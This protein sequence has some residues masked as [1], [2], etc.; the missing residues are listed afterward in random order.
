MTTWVSEKWNTKDAKERQHTLTGSR[1]EGGGGG[2]G[3]ALAL[4]S[5]LVILGI[6]MM[7][8]EHAVERHGE[9]VLEIDRVCRNGGMQDTMWN[10]FTGRSVM[11]CQVEGK[12][13]LA[14]Y[15][16]GKLV[17]AFFKEKMQTLREVQR[18]LM[19]AGYVK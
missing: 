10:P 4:V 5:V 18:Y 14:V 13:G 11:I 1:H 3:L 15:E 16:D 12:W 17:T 9:A 8:A 6:V 19:N 7:S 2:I